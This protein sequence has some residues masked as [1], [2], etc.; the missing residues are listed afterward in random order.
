MTPP[1]HDPRDPEQHLSSGYYQISESG[2]SEVVQGCLRGSFPYHPI[3]R[4]APHR[5]EW[6]LGRAILTGASQAIRDGISL[7]WQIIR[8]VHE[9]DLLVST[10]AT[11]GVYI[12]AADSNDE[13]GVV[14]IGW[15]ENIPRRLRQLQTSNPNRLTLLVTLEAKQEHE[16]MLHRRWSCLRVSKD[17]EWFHNHPA[18]RRYIESRSPEQVAESMRF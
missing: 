9:T 3:R 8:D 14:K 15:S 11:S 6:Q 12:V 10:S 18:L 4:D 1:L 2:T 7:Q 17:L 13:H 5:L 16:F